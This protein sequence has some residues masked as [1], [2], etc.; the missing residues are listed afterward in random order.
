GIPGLTTV[1]SSSSTNKFLVF[2]TYETYRAYR[3][4]LMLQ[5][6]AEQE[7]V[8]IIKEKEFIINKSEM[9]STCCIMRI[10]MVLNQ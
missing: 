1:S 7:M 5:Q 9:N 10:D 4:Q 2:N 6:M 8:S 3:H